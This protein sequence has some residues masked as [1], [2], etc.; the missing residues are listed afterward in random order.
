MSNLNDI[1]AIKRVKYAYLRALDLKQWDELAACLTEDATAAYSDG[2]Y[3]FSGRDHIM[4]F[5]RG[6]L[7]ADTKITVHR[8]Q[9]PEIDVIGET[10]ATATWALDDVVID[11]AANI[12]LRGAAFYRDEYVKTADGWKI[13]HTGYQRVYEEVESRGDTPSLRLT[14]NRWS[15]KTATVKHG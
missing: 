14:A 15:Q 1:E 10:S 4:Q 6:A 12:T 5:L 7:G 13:R 3:S 8:V 2:K 11:T 9:Q